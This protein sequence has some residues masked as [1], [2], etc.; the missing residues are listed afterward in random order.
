MFFPKHIFAELSYNKKNTHK[1]KVCSNTF[2]WEK[3]TDWRCTPPSPTVGRYLDIDYNTCISR[4]NTNH[5]NVQ[6]VGIS[7]FTCVDWQR[8]SPQV[9]Y[10]CYLWYVYFF[11]LLQ[12]KTKHSNK[13]KIKMIKN[14]QKSPSP[15][16]IYEKVY[17]EW[18]SAYYRRVCD[19]P[20]PTTKRFVFYILFFFC[21]IAQ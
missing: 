6:C 16:N 9:N 17:A 5:D 20:A 18:D 4:C 10:V 14:T 13:K 1:H 7:F 19:T 12:R 2:T 15:E 8:C 11:L 21:E 3:I